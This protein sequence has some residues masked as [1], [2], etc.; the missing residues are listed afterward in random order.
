MTPLRHITHFDH[1]FRTLRCALLASALFAGVGASAGGESGGG[2][3]GH[4]LPAKRASTENVEALM[5]KI[6]LPL[7]YFFQYLESHSSLLPAEFREKIMAK[8]YPSSGPGIYNALETISPRIER[9]C[10][11]RYGRRVPA[12]SINGK[13]CFDATAVAQ[14][15]GTRSVFVQTVAMVAHEYLHVFYKLDE[16]DEP[17]AI[18]LQTV[19][20][21]VVQPSAENVL[22]ELQEDGKRGLKMLVTLLEGNLVPAAERAL[23]PATICRGLGIVGQIPKELDFTLERRDLGL[24]LIDAQGRKLLRALHL[25]ME[26][27]SKW[28]DFEESTAGTRKSLASVLN[29]NGDETLG[30]ISVTEIRAGDYSTLSAALKEASQ[31]ARLLLKEIR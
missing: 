10:F 4:V 1:V 8:L 24:A 9:E 21:R 14:E 19:A 20:A 26:D 16:N 17:L 11:D 13:I 27:M 22:L 6:K 23:S 29:A 15:I 12:S 18:A 5:P 31:V 28:C 2:G 7:T 25:R 3:G 30:I